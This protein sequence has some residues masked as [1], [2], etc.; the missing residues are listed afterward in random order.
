M[1]RKKLTAELVDELAGKTTESRRTAVAD[2]HE[3]GFN[4][5][6][7]VKSLL[8]GKAGVNGNPESR[9]FTTLN[10]GGQK[11]WAYDLGD[12]QSLMYKELNGHYWNW[13]TPQG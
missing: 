3:A 9:G 12:G 4:V 6:S 10:F 8:E 13:P 2:L 5:R 1:D 7:Y 11:I